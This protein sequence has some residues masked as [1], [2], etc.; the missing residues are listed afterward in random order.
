MVLE[1]INIRWIRT[2]SQPYWK[3]LYS[4]VLQIFFT[5]IKLKPRSKQGIRQWT[6]NRFTPLIIKKP[7]DQNYQWKTTQSSPQ[8][9]KIIIY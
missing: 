3:I 4:I 7:V 5:N 6:V 9:L 8:S 1:L 2:G